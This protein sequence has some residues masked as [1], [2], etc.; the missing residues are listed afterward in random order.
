[1]AKIFNLSNLDVTIIFRA[2]SILM[3]VSGHFGFVNIPGGSYFLIFLSGYNF[4]LF[5]AQKVPNLVNA[6]IEFSGKSFLVVY[7]NFLKKIIIPTLLYT[8]FL[9]AVLGEF[10]LPGLLLISNFYGPMYAN[11]LTFWFLEVLVQI[12]LLFGLLFFLNKIFFFYKFCSY[13]FFSF[14]FFVSYLISVVCRC[15]WDTSFWLDRFPHLMIYM[16]FA[17]ACV[18]LSKTKKLKLISSLIISFCFLEFF[19]FGLDA[20]VVFLL[21]SI[22]CTIWFPCLKLPTILCKT[23]KIIALSS[24]FIYL[25]HFQ[26]LSLIRKFNSDIEPVY[27]VLFALLVGVIIS[28]FW[29]LKDRAFVF[30]SKFI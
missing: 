4:I 28:K 11:G 27:T 29:K 12:Y 26:S 1:M 15:I 23:L 19:I 6:D 2:F 16:F 24:L 22:Y 5:T 21:F 20:K 10:H 3:I 7:F 17:G 25:T 9:Y 13:C 18:A 8:V 30:G 14:G